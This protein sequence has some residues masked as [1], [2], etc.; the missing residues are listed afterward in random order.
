MD[1]HA[2]LAEVRRLV[3][4]ARSMPMSASAVVN[5]AELLQ[6]LDELRDGLSA[7]FSDAQQVVS[8]RDAVV[9]EGRVQ[10]DQIVQDA[11]NER[12]R[13]VSDTEVFRVAKRRADEVLESARTEADELRKE[14]DDYVDG[15]LAN[16][17]IT[18][19]RT[20]EAVKRGRERLAGRSALDSLT[21]D[22]ADKIKL[23]EHLEG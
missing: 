9:D 12:E 21:A 2:Q 7:A 11:H 5:R 10:A 14:T 16:F 18:L 4:Q 8:D 3:E 23:P 15:K 20:M 6:L 1:V 22:E 19:E 13:I 17:E